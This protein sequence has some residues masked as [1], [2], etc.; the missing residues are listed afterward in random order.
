MMN[1]KVV[2]ILLAVA[3]ASV[4]AMPTAA[5]DTVR[6][7]GKGDDRTAVFRTS[8]PCI[9]DWSI[10]SDFPLLANFEMHSSEVRTINPRCRIHPD[11]PV[12]D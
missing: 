4:A 3:M 9:L 8:G 10:T 2:C 7:T 6:F 12:A 11:A 5:S 1:H